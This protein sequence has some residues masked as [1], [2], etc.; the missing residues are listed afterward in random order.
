MTP[1]IPFQEI[2][3]YCG[4]AK[5]VDQEHITS[6]KMSLEGSF[7]PDSDTL[8][9]LTAETGPLAAGALPNADCTSAAGEKALW[10]AMA[11]NPVAKIKAP[12]GTD[13]QAEEVEPKTI[14]EN[15]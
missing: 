5:K 2:Y 8:A 4:K 11:S 14:T 12:K 3:Y 1:L 6:D 15:L 7:K 10:G 13:D 9:A